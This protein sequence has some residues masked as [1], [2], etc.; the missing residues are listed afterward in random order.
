MPDSETVIGHRNLCV[1]RTQDTDEV[2]DSARSLFA[3]FAPC[4]MFGHHDDR[5]G[6][7]MKLERRATVFSRWNIT[8][9]HKRI[10]VTRQMMGIP[11]D[12]E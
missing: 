12:T 8:L 3:A 6:I 5:P 11:M 10:M 4:R 9:P 7:E 2:L 1:V